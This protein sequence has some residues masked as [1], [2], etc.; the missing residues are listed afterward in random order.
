[1]DNKVSDDPELVFLYSW[2]YHFHTKL[3]QWSGFLKSSSKIWSY[4]QATGMTL[5]NLIDDCEEDAKA[6]GEECNVCWTN[7]EFNQEFYIAHPDKK[8]AINKI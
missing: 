4:V 5:V 7:I 6:Q 8:L 3:V 1:M 2:K